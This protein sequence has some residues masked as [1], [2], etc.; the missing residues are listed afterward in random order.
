MVIILKN[1]QK[2]PE[3]NQFGKDVEKLEPCPSAG[4]HL[5]L[6]RIPCDTESPLTP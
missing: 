2:P 5:K 3:N 1:E 4:G 6:D